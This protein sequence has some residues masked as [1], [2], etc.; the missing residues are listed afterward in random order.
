MCEYIYRHRAKLCLKST[1]WAALAAF[2]LHEKMILP[3]VAY[4]AGVLRKTGRPVAPGEPGLEK[5]I[6]DMWQTLD[7]A[8]GVG[9]AAQQVN[10]PLQLF[11]VNGPGVRQVFM[12]ARVLEYSAALCSDTEGCLSIPGIWEEAERPESIILQYQDEHFVTHTQTFDGP[13]ARMIQ[14]EY[15]HTQGTLYLDHLKP[16]RRA[17]LQRKLLAIARGKIDRPYPMRFVK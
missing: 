5:L 16:L 11:I 1:I 4:G 6:A 15:D 14:H 12:N 13:A 9:L 7:R 8:G 3:I 17:L 2:V 10:R